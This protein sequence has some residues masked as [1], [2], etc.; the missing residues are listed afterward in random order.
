[1]INNMKRYIFIVTAVV[2]FAASF[3]LSCKDDNNKDII[4]EVKNVVFRAPSVNLSLSDEENTFT[5][6]L[7]YNLEPA[8]ASNI[9]SVNW[10]SSNTSVAMVTQSGLVTSISLGE[11]TITV[12]IKVTDGRTF[13]DQCTVNVVP[14]PI[15]VEDVE[16]VT[17]EGLIIPPGSSESLLYRILPEDASNKSVLWES[18][19]EEVATVSQ[20][21]EVT[22]IKLGSAVIVVTTVEGGFKARYTV[23][24]KVSVTGVVIEKPAKTVFEAGEEVEL[25]A[26]VLPDDAT[27]QNISWKSSNTAI[28]TVNGNGKVT[29]VAPGTATITVTTEDGEFEDELEIEVVGTYV[30]GVKL[31]DDISYTI[32]YENINHTLTLNASVE[33]GNATNKKVLWSSSADGVATVNENGNVSLKGA[34][35]AIIT[36]TTEDGGFN[37]DLTITVS[38]FY[39]W[40]SRSKFSIYGWNSGYDDSSAAGPGWSSQAPYDGGARVTRILTDSDGEF[41]HSSWSPNIPYPNW[42]IVDLGEDLDFDA[43]MLRRRTDNGGTARGYYVFTSLVSPAAPTF[44]WAD[45]GDY[46]FNPTTN[47]RQVTPLEKGTVK[48]RY[49]ML[50]FD[51]KHQSNPKWEGSSS[52]AM[53]SQFGLYKKKE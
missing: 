43:V 17:E 35:T 49:I 19:N 53:F 18:K 13:T 38:E 10:S 45:R 39:S 41:W 42:F 51:T 23:T 22:A 52:Y 32:V 16:F 4:I 5:V 50:Y 36:A 15:A 28:A 14:A 48:A 6:A 30:T 25:T 27:V 7:T 8:K 37:D 24:V 2:F 11:T 3:L 40:L 20:E 9:E 26:S 46:E 29:T 44:A 34:G 21:G 31:G 12:T 33:P 47:N 1:M